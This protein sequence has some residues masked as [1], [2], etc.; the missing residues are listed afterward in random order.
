MSARAGGQAARA[1]AGKN[2]GRRLEKIIELIERQANDTPGVRVEVRKR[3]RDKDTNKLREHDVVITYSAGH[4]KP[5]VMA[6]ECR[7]R[8]RPVT[9]EAVE[10]FHTKCQRTGIHQGAIVSG[11]GFATTALTK[12]ASLGIRCLELREAENFDWCQAPGILQY[13]KN[14]KHV[15]VGAEFDHGTPAEPWKLFEGGAKELGIREGQQI[16]VNLLNT[17]PVERILQANLP[18]G[19]VIHQRFV[20]DSPNFIALDTNGKSWKCAKLVVDILFDMTENFIPLRFHTY[21][22]AESGT[23][24]SHAATAELQVGEHHMTLAITGPEDGEKR[25]IISPTKK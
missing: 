12:A 9:V 20:D 3:I 14:L 2:T 1:Y 13:I 4:H 7:D 21:I 10:S 17:I 6:L 18:A 23:E 19:A 5:L 25:V 24:L 8:S 15:H 22:D 16:G 11:K